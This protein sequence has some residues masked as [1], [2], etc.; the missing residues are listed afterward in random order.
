MVGRRLRLRGAVRR[1]PTAAQRLAKADQSL[2]SRQSVLNELVAH[3]V[4]DFLRFQHRKE[5]ARPLPVAKSSAFEGSLALPHVLALKIPS[6]IKMLNQRQRILDVDQ[7]G[8][9]RSSIIRRHFLL[10]GLRLRSRRPQ[11]AAVENRLCERCAQILGGSRAAQRNDGGIE[12]RILHA[13]GG[14]ERQ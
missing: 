11:S 10:L 14:S 2:Q 8:N 5:I 12:G 1:L 4:E 13:S 3:R 7:C 6:G 9:D